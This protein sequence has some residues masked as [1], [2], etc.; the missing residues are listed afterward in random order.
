MFWFAGLL[1]VLWFL[2]LI[3]SFTFGGLIHFVPLLALIMTVAGIVRRRQDKD[4]EAEPRR[5]HVPPTP[6]PK[7]VS[8]R[9][10]D[11]KACPQ[12]LGRGT[13]T[14][15]VRVR[16]DHAFLG[17]IGVTQLVPRSVTCPTCVG[18]GWVT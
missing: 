1:V 7:T 18:K 9:P 10:P 13:V 11:A 3:A 15:M 4:L 17:A 16:M 12:C 8:P 5:V 14:K 2:A 6:Q